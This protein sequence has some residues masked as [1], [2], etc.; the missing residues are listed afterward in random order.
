MTPSSYVS[1]KYDEWHETCLGSSWWEIV[2]NLASQNVQGDSFACREYH[3]S[4]AKTDAQTHCPHASLLGG[5][6]CQN[7][8]ADRVNFFCTMYV[9]LKVLGTSGRSAFFWCVFL[10]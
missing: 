1:A 4:A 7:S 2:T 8:K 3:L 9:P 5:G 6:V 10:V